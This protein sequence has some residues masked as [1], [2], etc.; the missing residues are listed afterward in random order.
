MIQTKHFI[1]LF[2]LFSISSLSAQNITKLLIEN[3]WSAYDNFA[4]ID[5]QTNGKAVLEY[6]YCSYCSGNRDTIDW[7]LDKKILTLGT[8]SLLIKSAS[9][10]SISTFQ[11]GQEFIFKAQKKLK[12]DKL[13][14]ENII[15]FLMQDTPLS[16]KI[17]S[18]K[19][20]NSNAQLIQFKENNQMWIDDSKNRGQWAIKSFY[21]STFL[22]YINRFSVNRNF[23]LLKIKSLK[24]GKL[25]GQPIPSI[26]KGSPFELE[27]SS[28]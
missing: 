13:K 26:T 20:K 19:F 21:G 15:N 12:P 22:I 7:T 24:K 9:S 28:N 5:F 23:P 11:Y 4:I 25:I 1:F 6:A 10:S 14:K 3:K 2:F 8:D 27:I 18:D 16:V 17:K